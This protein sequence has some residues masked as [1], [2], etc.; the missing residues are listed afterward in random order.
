MYEV[1]IQVIQLQ[2]SEGLIQAGG[3]VLWSVM[4]AP[5]LLQE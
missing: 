2:I 1:E 4:S 3:D 5:Q